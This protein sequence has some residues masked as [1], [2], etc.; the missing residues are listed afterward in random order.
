MK[1]MG[2]AVHLSVPP[3]QPEPEPGCVI[4]AHLARQ[5][6]QARAEGDLSRV[7]DCNVRLRGHEHRKAP[8]PR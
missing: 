4:C 1:T 3:R 5:R 7:S 2:P 8:I 6:T